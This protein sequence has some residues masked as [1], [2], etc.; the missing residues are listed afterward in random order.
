MQLRNNCSAAVH[1][2]NVAARG[3]AMQERAARNAAF[4]K[5]QRFVVEQALQ[6]PQYVMFGVTVRSKRVRNYVD[7]LLTTP[8]F[9]QVWLETG[10][11]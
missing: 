8:K 11:G 2:P 1:P 7:G 9:H 10:S 4:A 3:S 5:L 6:A